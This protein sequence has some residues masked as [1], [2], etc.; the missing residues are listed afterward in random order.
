ME[1]DVGNINRLINFFAGIGA[2]RIEQ[3]VVGGRNVKTPFVDYDKI[4]FNLVA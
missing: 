4:E 1:K 3:R 2:I